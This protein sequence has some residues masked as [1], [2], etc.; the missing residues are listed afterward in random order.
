MTTSP[1]HALQAFA[2]DSQAVRVVSKGVGTSDTLGPWFVAK[3][4]CA[5]LGIT[6]HWNVIAKLD[7]D[8]KGLQTLESLGGPQE[9]AVISESGLYTII[10]RSQGATTPGKPAHT[11]RKWVTSEVLPAIRKTGSYAEPGA[12]LTSEARLDKLIGL[13]EQMLAVLPQ[14]VQAQGQ[15][16]PA[17]RKTTG[18]P[19]HM[20][21]VNRILTLRTKGY[22]LDD[23]VQDTGFSQS[24]CWGV[25]SDRYKVL[26]S[27]RVSIDLRSHSARAADAAAKFERGS[28]N[29]RPLV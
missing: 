21:D 12:V 22:T 20:G 26:E 1:T 13:V 4:V 27:G 19:M 8:E 2:F 11:F 29:Q 16:Q 5:C 9:M 25:L 3:D 10:L 14:M 23:L 7:D 18:K 15:A 28:K 17:R 6:N 24:Q